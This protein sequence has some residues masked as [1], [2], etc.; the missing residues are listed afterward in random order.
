MGV[1][2]GVIDGDWTA[3]GFSLKT[4]HYLACASMLA[5]EEQPGALGK[6]L[7][8]RDNFMP[9]TCGQFYGFV[10]IL[11]KAALL[12]FRGT[13]SIGNCLTD[14]ETVL[15]SR[16]PYPGRVHVGF[17]EA[18]EDVWPEVRR[19][20]GSR[21]RAMPLW[22]AGHSLGGA[23]A[24]LASLR[25]SAERYSVRAV[26]TYGSPRVGDRQ[27]RDEY[28]LPN[29]RFVFDNDLV[30]HLPF[31]WCFKHVGHLKLL[32]HEGHLTEEQT[33]WKHR[34]RL[35]AGK[36]KHIQ[37]AHRHTH[38]PHHES[39]G[40]DWLA[41]HRLS[42][43]LEAIEKTVSRACHRK[44]HAHH[45]GLHRIG[46]HGIALERPVAQPEPAFD[47]SPPRKPGQPAL[48]VISPP[49]G[50]N[51]NGRHQ[52]ISEA[53]FIAAFFHQSSGLTWRQ[54]ERTNHRP[55]KAA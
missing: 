34:K 44:R 9:F 35:M 53:D 16:P 10:A 4:A 54:K 14:A 48:T 13:Q 39:I 8:L 31:R 26:Y 18:I 46:E 40:F 42:H 12:A 43:Y 5:Y 32:D 29:Y 37:R 38:E 21:C 49:L 24:T 11:G 20:L 1:M 22:L 51:A 50:S 3:R 7:G 23:M 52:K 45:I 28:H 36:A 41:D 15:A 17:A 27:F 30:P 47:T 19:L 25:L 2:D 33:A 6:R 55:A